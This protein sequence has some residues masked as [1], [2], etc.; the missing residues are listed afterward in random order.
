MPKKRKKNVEPAFIAEFENTAGSTER[1]GE[2]A[3]SASTVVYIIGFFDVRS[4]QLS[5][6]IDVFVLSRNE[7]T[8]DTVI[9]TTSNGNRNPY[10][11][12]R[13]ANIPTEFID[14]LF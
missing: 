4:R 12:T 1:I 8:R 13:E 14:A 7:I 6:F 11:L 2:R 10:T 9:F 3:F 5:V